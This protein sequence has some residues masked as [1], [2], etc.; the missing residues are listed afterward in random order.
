M[1]W[2]WDKVSVGHSAE[3]RGQLYLVGSSGNI[4]EYTDT[5]AH[6]HPHRHDVVNNRK[7]YM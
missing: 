6:T 4:R 7:A 1:V 5:H 3:N 2:V